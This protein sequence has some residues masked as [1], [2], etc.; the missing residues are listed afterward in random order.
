MS[1]LEKIKKT[2]KANVM[3]VKKEYPTID[4][5]KFVFSILIVAIH[6][7]LLKVNESYSA[8]MVSSLFFRLG[9]PFFFVV[10]GFFLSDKLYS[11]QNR[12]LVECSQVTRKYCIKNLPPLILWG[13]IGLIFNLIELQTKG[14]SISYLL[15]YS[16]RTFFYPLNAMWYLLASIIG[17]IIMTIFYLKC[18]SWRWVWVVYA[19]VS[20]IFVLLCNNYF[21][22]AEGTALEPLIRLYSK[23]FVSARNGVFLAPVYM[24]MGFV[25]RCDD[26][27]AWFSKHKYVSVISLI[28]GF[29]FLTVEA[30]VLFGC[31]RYDDRGFF[32]SQLLL[33]PSLVLVSMF[34]STKMKLPYRLLRRL[35]TSVFYLHCTIRTV[36]QYF[37]RQNMV[38]TGD[39]IVLFVVTT[40][41]TILISLISYGM[42]NKK[43]SALFG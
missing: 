27:Q 11:I 6:T 42:N 28:C 17:A 14:Q 23:V 21:F 2:W 37:L 9:V 18:K 8:W 39:N 15:A 19:I 29:V 7:S 4:L 25:I 33:I 40:L 35:S 20:Y 43:V 10:S 16:C 22:L 12:N 26:A 36:V 5:L 24:G 13:G 3:F 1:L 31:T 34:Y 41:L 30:T 32:I 38:E